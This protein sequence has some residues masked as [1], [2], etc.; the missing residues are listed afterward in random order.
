MSWSVDKET[1]E[2]LR[3]AT[4]GCYLSVGPVTF[5]QK[6]YT[7]GRCNQDAK[8][9]ITIFMTL[10]QNCKFPCRYDV[11]GCSERVLFGE[12]M[13]NHEYL[14]AYRPSSCLMKHC[15]WRGCVRD[16][17]QHLSE[18]HKESSADT[19]D[20]MLNVNEP[21]Q[22]LKLV[23]F[24]NGQLL[25]L[26]AVYDEVNGLRIE[27]SPLLSVGLPSK[28]N[29]ILTSLSSDTSNTTEL[30]NNEI[31]KPVKGLL[32]PRE[33]LKRLTDNKILLKFSI[34]NNL[35]GC[36]CCV[37]ALPISIYYFVCNLNHAICSKCYENSNCTECNT[38]FKRRSNYQLMKEVNAP[39]ACCN[40]VYECNFAGS[41]EKLEEHE[42]DCLYDKCLV[43]NCSWQGVSTAFIKH[44]KQKH[45]DITCRDRELTIGSKDEINH[46]ICMDDQMFILNTISNNHENLKEITVNLI[47]SYYR[48]QRKWK[49]MITLQDNSLLLVGDICQLHNFTLDRSCSLRICSTLLQN[50]KNFKATLYHTL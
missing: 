35:K 40:A 44:I 13:S 43:R 7:C 23:N 3:C 10:A 12:K 28:Y 34:E 33:M 18:N 30:K 46:F 4:C 15:E 26:E 16:I 1:V 19:L 22:T 45:R 29:L 50:Y 14:C 24:K 42:K 39:H 2:Y 38:P 17:T 41:L 11:H 37:C 31:L 8:N 36:V 20:F 5:R 47:N 48:D 21:M 27:V 49:V 32:V 9:V 6:H 25:L